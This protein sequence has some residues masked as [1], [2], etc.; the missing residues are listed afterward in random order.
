MHGKEAIPILDRKKR[1]CGSD[2][3]VIIIHL[4]NIESR[5][6]ESEKNSGIIASSCDF[7]LVM[8]CLCQLHSMKSGE[9]W[10]ETTSQARFTCS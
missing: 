10:I 1:S 4:A 7:W 9:I 6:G 5:T 8:F 3:V 2:V